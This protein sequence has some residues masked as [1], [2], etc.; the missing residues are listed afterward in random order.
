MITMGAIKLTGQISGHYSLLHNNY[1]A[2][3]YAIRQCSLKLQIVLTIFN[4][5][6][7]IMLRNL[8][9][10]IFNNCDFLN[11]LNTIF[12][13]LTSFSMH[14]NVCHGLKMALFF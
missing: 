8:Y 10:N 6:A 1:Y 5:Y 4:N 3:H 2:Q 12:E 11:L 7:P 14:C 13:V 9:I